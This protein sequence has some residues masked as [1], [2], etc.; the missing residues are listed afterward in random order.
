MWHSFYTA[1]TISN[2]C[3][4]SLLA[5]L[6]PRYHQHQEDEFIMARLTLKTTFRVLLLLTAAVI[7][8]TSQAFAQYT[9]TSLVTTTQDPHLRNGWGMAYLPTGPFWISDED[10]GFSTV[11]D[12]NGTIVPLVVTIPPASTGTGSPTGMVANTTS[13]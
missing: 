11:Y 12:A 3:Q 2:V 10:T 5:R 7:L 4:A 8:Y 13:G 6:H 9:L 1:V